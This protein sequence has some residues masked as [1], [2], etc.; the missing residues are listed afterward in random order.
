MSVIDVEDLQK[1][2]DALQ[3]QSNDSKKK[4]QKPHYDSF[5]SLRKMK[6]I[7]YHRITRILRIILTFFLKF[8][9]LFTLFF[10][11]RKHIKKTIKH[12]FP[13]THI[14]TKKRPA[15]YIPHN[16]QLQESVKTIGNTTIIIRRRVPIS[17][18]SFTPYLHISSSKTAHCFYFK[19][20]QTQKDPNR[21][22]PRRSIWD[23]PVQRFQ[24][25][26][27]KKRDNTSSQKK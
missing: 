14:H 1:F 24:S 3:T 15:V 6:N 22:E 21:Y 18:Q 20:K 17:P 5:F 12:S 8:F 10:H 4:S 16:T 13:K 2:G 19:Q 25:K 26:N 11:T 23:V 27:P 7:F 9:K